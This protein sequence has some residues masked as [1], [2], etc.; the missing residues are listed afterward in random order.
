LIKQLKP[1]GTA[2]KHCQT[3]PSAVTSFIVWYDINQAA[4]QSPSTSHWQKVPL[5]HNQPALT[6]EYH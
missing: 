5:Q 1:A 6:F 3:A 2:A 4:A